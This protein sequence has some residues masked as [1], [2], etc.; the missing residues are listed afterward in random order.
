MPKC[1][2]HPKRKRGLCK[3]CHV[4]LC[5][6]PA[7]DCPTITAHDKYNILPKKRII[8]DI[9]H[10]PRSLRRR[11]STTYADNETSD[12]SDDEILSFSGITRW[13][14][15]EPR[16]HCSVQ[17]QKGSNIELT[18]NNIT[19]LLEKLPNKGY[20]VTNILQY[21]RTYRRAK[22]LFIEIINQLCKS[23]I[24]DNPSICY[25]FLKTK[26]ERKE[27]DAPLNNLIDL[28][29][30]GESTVSQ[31]CAAVISQSMS[32]QAARDRIKQR[33]NTMVISK[34]QYV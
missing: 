16:I 8:K 15:D 20:D 23:F 12:N 22:E 30:I 32:N 11:Q 5:C 27:E 29:L 25:Q 3:G 4:H 6:P 34:S 1:K 31:V 19:K 17:E 2:L 28:Y 33:E 21:G 18:A 26:T 14:K 7:D 9:A 13:Q 24:P 10:E